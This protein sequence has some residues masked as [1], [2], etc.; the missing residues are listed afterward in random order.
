[1][2][3]LWNKARGALDQHN[4]S[5]DTTSTEAVRGEGAARSTRDL[6]GKPPLRP[7][8]RPLRY[9][10]TVERT[11]SGER[12]K[13]KSL[14]TLGSASKFK[15]Y[16]GTPFGA[17]QIE[18]LRKRRQ[19]YNS[20]DVLVLDDMPEACELIARTFERM[21]SITLAGK[22]DEGRQLITKKCLDGNEAI[23]RICGEEESFA[24]ITVDMNLGKDSPS[25][26]EV[27]RSLR[28]AGYAGALM[29][30]LA[31]HPSLQDEAYEKF[32]MEVGADGI[33]L[34]DDPNLPSKLFQII[35]T[36]VSRYPD[37]KKK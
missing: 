2:R 21:P 6:R 32:M 16:A 19:P 22:N 15:Q 12:S 31:P 28:E 25:G 23:T 14:Q 36:L 11:L 20:A 26:R 35:S 9:I 33:L 5:S 13:S 10:P 1:M 29:Y 27:I 3:A 37:F 7:A 34:K 30:L 18:Q 4:N 17:K 8:S 24:L